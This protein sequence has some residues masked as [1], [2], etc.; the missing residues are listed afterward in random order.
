MSMM[1]TVYAFYCINNQLIYKSHKQNT[2]YIYKCNDG[3]LN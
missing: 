2:M 1:I 3:I